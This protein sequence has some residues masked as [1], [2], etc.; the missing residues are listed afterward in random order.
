MKYQIHWVEHSEVK[1]LSSTG[2]KHIALVAGGMSAEREVSLV[3]SEGVSKALIELGYKV[4]FVDMGADIAVKLQEIKPD[5]VFNCLHGTYGEDGCLPGLLNIMRI[6]YTHSGVLS[7]ALAFDKIHSR[8]WF[9]TNNINMAESIVVSKNDNISHL[10]KLAYREEF[11]G[12]TSPRT[13]V[14]KNDCADASTGSTHKLPLEVEFR[15]MANDP[16]K[17]PYVIKPL[18]QGSSIGIEVIF[19]EDDF[20][21]ADYNF[22]YGDQVIIEQYIKGRELQV[23]V[24]NGKA[25]GALEIKLLKNRFYDYEAKYTEGFA[26]HLCP[27]PLPANLYEKLLIESEKIYKTMNC[28]GPARAEFILEEQKNKLYALE[29]NTHPGMT[30]LSI[31]PEIAAYAGINFTNLIEEIIK[32]AS[33]ES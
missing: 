12:D 7:S 11:V 2:K 1:I 20:N 28:K 5:I 8:S 25:L 17:R 21:F 9:L 3:S 26:E 22:P 33:F 32:T 15:E 27:A 29:I 18:T 13:A 14:Y 30:P 31:V 23:A 24:L 19:E 6:P 10:S 16:M 4:T